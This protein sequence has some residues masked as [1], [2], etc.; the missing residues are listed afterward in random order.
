M[1][2]LALVISAFGPYAGRQELDFSVLGDH[3]IYLVYGDTG[4]GKTSIFDA[5]SYALYGEASGRERNSVMLRSDFATPETKTFVSLLFEYRGERYTVTRSPEYERPKLRGGGTTKEPAGADLILPDGSIVSGMRAVNE[6]I[7]HVLGLS[8]EQFSQIIMIAQGDFRRFLLSDTKDRSA[9]LRRIFATRPYRDFQEEL[10]RRMLEA[11]RNLETETTS[12]LQYAKS[13][14]AEGE[15]Q[16]V[17][18]IRS[19]MESP[20]AYR[21]GELTDAMT[22]LLQE[23]ESEI[24]LKKTE[25][26]E[27]WRKKSELSALITNSEQTNKQLTDLNFQKL[28]FRNLEEQRSQMC[29]KEHRL[30]MGITALRTVKPVWEQYCAAQLEWNNLSL[31]IASAEKD[32][33]MA[34]GKWEAAA[35][36]LK[37]EQG[38]EGEREAFAE[39]ISRL[40]EQL[41]R[42]EQ[43]ERCHLK[44]KEIRE[45]LARNIEETRKAKLLLERAEAE[46][47]D[48]QEEMAALS[49]L[50]LQQ[51]RLELA[52]S[53]V[54][55]KKQAIEGLSDSIE[56][57]RSR[58]TDWTGFREEFEAAESEFEETENR[59]RRME[60]AFLREQAGILAQ[61]LEEG[62]PCPVCGSKHH[63]LLAIPS[64]EAPSEAELKNVRES[65]KLARSE[66][67]NLSLASGAAKLE[68]EVMLAECMSIAVRYIPDLQP[69]QLPQAALRLQTEI[70][71]ELKELESK[72]ERCQR[73]FRRRE[74][75]VS[76]LSGTETEIDRICREMTLLEQENAQCEVVLSRLEGE[77]DT[78]SQGLVFPDIK[79]A[80]DAFREKRTALYLLR[81]ELD[82]AKQ[83]WDSALSA[84]EKAK[85]V[86]SERLS[87]KTKIEGSVKQY[88]AACE[89]AL[90]K[91]GFSS[92][93][94]Y[95][96]ALITEEIVKNVENELSAYRESIRITSR[97]IFRLEAET[98]GKAYSNIEALQEELLEVEEKVIFLTDMLATM[99]S[100]HL[101]NANAHDNLRATRNRIGKREEDYLC[102]KGLSD[103][104][105]GDIGGKAKITFETYLQT[106]Y[107]SRIIN[108]ANY[109][110]GR[111]SK[112][113]FELMRRRE[114]DSLRSQSGLELDVFDHY[115]GKSRDVRSLSGGESF[116]AS[117]SLALGLSDLV[118][119]TAGGI[120]LDTMFIDEG[121][122]ALDMEA[123]D[124]AVT[125]L[126]QV[127]GNRRLIGI[128]SHIGELAGRIDRQIHVYRSNAGSYV[129]IIS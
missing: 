41:P 70:Q 33:N 52:Y 2:P 69:Q 110:F 128:I 102:Y 99:Q 79:T 103:T 67:E 24:T 30:K 81:Q 61:T 117:L 84:H 54:L 63:P 8:R 57:W 53:Q 15:S 42:Y 85:A 74:L 104:A 86:L 114:P 129:E 118:Q 22:E 25:L 44:Q 47:R 77:Y 105:N 90:E 59:L 12:F 73:D 26:E 34:A 46:R 75:L 108:A 23:Q 122:G 27:L 31:E 48:R 45:A 112:G 51:E 9:I 40:S 83:E 49:G 72:Q 124:V 106:A 78:L 127:A 19:W 64:R 68:T 88:K 38:R 62:I 6:K 37:E 18:A 58:K 111:M 11:K 66:W 82:K 121:F 125:T 43:I 91:A 71:L 10:K 60:S 87:R 113:R 93:K 76:T 97:E 20:G 35:E 94:E 95:V 32:E 107:F 17:A 4:A 21:L 5:V 65:A 56:R 50:E 101:G 39:E 119:Q 28:E 3:G 123:L 1:R 98:Q 100:R 120:Q 16:A 13:V 36:F 92:E 126:Q 80:E 115:T 96:N 29:E 55:E 14:F 89:E 7:E 116:Q 109:R